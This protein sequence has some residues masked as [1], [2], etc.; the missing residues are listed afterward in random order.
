MGRRGVCVCVCVCVCVTLYAGFHDQAQHKPLL[1]ESVLPQGVGTFLLC[2]QYF[3]FA[4]LSH[5]L[6]VTDSAKPPI[7]G[8][9]ICLISP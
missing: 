2:F 7:R 1:T 5:L 6:E 9:V 8:C 4:L 3:H